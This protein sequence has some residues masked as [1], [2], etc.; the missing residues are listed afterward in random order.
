MAKSME[1]TF[2]KKMRE[3]SFQLAN[4]C[5][6]EWQLFQFLTLLLVFSVIAIKAESL[7]AVCASFRHDGLMRIS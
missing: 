7:L 4:V 2:R 6:C 3:K 5:D 1:L